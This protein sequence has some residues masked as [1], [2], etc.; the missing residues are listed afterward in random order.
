M[1]IPAELLSELRR[2]HQRRNPQQNEPVLQN[3]N[4]KPFTRDQLSG[5]IVRL[6]RRSGVHHALPYR[7]RQT[8]AYDLFLRGATPVYVGQALGVKAD[9]VVKHFWRAAPY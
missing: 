4:G 5:R 1:R 7:F 8:S 2:E 6:G 9:T 3:A